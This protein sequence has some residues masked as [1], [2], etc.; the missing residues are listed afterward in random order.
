M[1]WPSLALR[2]VGYL[3]LGQLLAFLIAWLATIFLGLTGAEVFATSLEE[4]A[5]A[6]AVKQVIASLAYDGR[7]SVRIEPSPELREELRRSPRMKVAAFNSITGEPVEGSSAE[8]AN[9]LARVNEIS[10]SH[11]HFTLP[12]DS[13]ESRLG[14]MEPRR[15]P[16]G[17]LHVA[18]YGQTFVLSDVYHALQDELEWLRVYLVAVVLMSVTTAWFAVRQGLWP[19]RAIAQ[20]ASHI[21]MDSLDQ[22]LSSDQAPTE[23]GPLV[24]AINDALKRLDAGVARQRR[25]TANAAHEL[26][27][28]V[29]ILS[30]RLDAPE[31]PTFKTDL[32]R[33]ARRIC[34]IVEQL[35]TAARLERRP[36]ESDQR[37]DI[38]AV[39]RA[40]AADAALLAIRAERQI[41]FEAPPGELRVAGNRT[42]IE[43]VLANLIDNALHAEPEGGLVFVKV[44]DRA[45]VE[46]IDHG[47][48]I[49]ECDREMI[50]EPFWRKSE[51]KPGTGLG[52]SIAKELVSI[53]G[54]QI[55]VEETP[56]GGATFKLA[57]PR[58]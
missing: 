54:G 50:F 5:A 10:P 34:N 17:R 11:V 45:V 38:I 27:T 53:H 7:G 35:L 8:L 52:L 16:F 46:V 1:S 31:E 36:A 37:I 15:T 29:A 25:F 44:T 26:R 57:F 42:A 41:A 3:A 48:G 13:K 6:R 43:L 56:G 39:A 9:A 2:V 28:P 47:E 24:D 20:E 4:L 40:M 18:V 12:G 30:A 19:L 49:A 21:D 14:M 23:I 58:P 33:D 22:R 55:W 32:K 51:T